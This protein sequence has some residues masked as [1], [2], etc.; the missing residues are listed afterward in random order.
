MY[1]FYEMNKHL[2]FSNGN[3]GH[4]SYLN[5]EENENVISKFDHILFFLERAILHCFL[6]LQV[7]ISSCSC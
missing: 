6:L 7:S 2:A 1:F 5:G 3:A 4:F